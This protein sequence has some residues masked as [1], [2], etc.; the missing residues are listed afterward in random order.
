M[1]KYSAV[2][3]SKLMYP[4]QMA[5]YLVS[6]WIRLVK[7]NPLIWIIGAAVKLFLLLEI[8]VAT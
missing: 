6:T 7:E 8:F 3:E 1:F 4:W 5:I 2:Q